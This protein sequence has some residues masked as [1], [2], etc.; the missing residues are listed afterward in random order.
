[1]IRMR[2]PVGDWRNPLL[3]HGHHF[4]A[5]RHFPTPCAHGFT[6]TALIA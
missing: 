2:L 4:A 6:H 1:M 3:T 5:C